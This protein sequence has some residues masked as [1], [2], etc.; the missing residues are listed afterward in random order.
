MN[1][2]H[3]RRRF[4]GQTAGVFSTATLLPRIPPLTQAGMIL[5][6]GIVRLQPEIEPLVKLIENTPRQRLLEKIGQRVKD[7]VSYREILAGL[8]LAAIRNVQPRPAVGFKFHAVLL[9]EFN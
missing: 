1:P 9:G 4:L 6:H 8:F 5:D 7:G 2:H 3:S